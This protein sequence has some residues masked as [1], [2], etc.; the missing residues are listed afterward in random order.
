MKRLLPSACSFAVTTVALVS[1]I[2]PGLLA[3][4]AGQSAKTGQ[5]PVGTLDS[6]ITARVDKL[7]EK[8]DKPD[9][10]GCALG[11]VKDGQ[12]IYK[13][14]YG[15]ANLDYNIPI[16][17]KSVFDVKAISNQITAMS[18]LLLAKQGKLSL[19][20]EIQKYL[21]EVPRYQSPITIRH[22]IHQTGGI[23]ELDDLTELAGM[24][25]QDVR[26]TQDDYLGLIARQK[27]LNHKPGEEFLYTDTGYFLLPLIV[28]RVSGKSLRE[29]A[30]ENIF[31]PL[32]MTNTHFHDDRNLMVKNRV[33]GYDG[34]NGG[35]AVVPAADD[36]L[37]GVSGLYA[38]VEDLFLWDQNFYHN[39]LGGGSDLIN[40]EVSPGMLNDGEKTN[41]AFGL[42]VGEY[43]GLK[44]I[45]HKGGG[46]G[47][48]SLVGRFPE[49]NFSI[50]CLCNA[51]DIGVWGLFDQVADI[52]LADQFKQGAGGASETAAAAPATISVP[53]KELAS[54]TGIYFDPITVDSNR[55]YMKDGKL[56]IDKGPGYVLSPLGQNHF[57]L[58]G[59]P[60]APVEIVFVPPIAGG[61]M[62]EQVIWGG[63][64]RRTFDAVQTETLTSAQLAEFTGKYLSDELPGATFT[65]SIKDGK[66]V[67]QVRNG[68]TVFS[69]RALVLAWTDTG[70]SETPLT[71]VFA[72]AFFLFGESVIVRFTRNQQNAVSGFTLST[73]KVRRVRFNKR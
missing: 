2:A 65:L 21:P 58:V 23:R 33:T 17:P 63:K 59:A 10:P 36:P 27:E 34:S 56:M 55:F 62:Q 71:P 14:G 5:A 42:F 7:F 70:K 1:F 45:S 52:F 54:L 47:F 11:I 68:I 72:D 30:E 49:Q 38:S 4:E 15:M 32:G 29:F 57:K 51:T 12:L 37:V 19:D 60:G 39:K 43:K 67:L 73:R 40:E 28:K 8:W 24:R 46:I 48:Q 64:T 18:I 35:F 50:I 25:H 16:S 26:L 66:L 44:R 61:P 53:E 6:S 22:L 3:Q 20:D 69:D 13:R 41:Y 31:K 9:S